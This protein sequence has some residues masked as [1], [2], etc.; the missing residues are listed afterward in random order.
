MSKHAHAGSLLSQ[1][2]TVVRYNRETTVP[3][4]QRLRY[5]RENSYVLGK[6]KGFK[7][8]FVVIRPKTQVRLKLLTKKTHKRAKDIFPSDCCPY[9]DPKKWH[10]VCSKFLS[11]VA[12]EESI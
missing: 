3:E 9:Q 5:C 10:P 4:R 12:E 7:L 6:L 1:P 8:L 11:A 2:L